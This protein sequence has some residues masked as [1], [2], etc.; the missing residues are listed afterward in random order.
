MHNVDHDEYYNNY[1]ISNY[2]NY[3]NIKTKKILKPHI[4]G[5]YYY[6]NI[7]IYNK[8]LNIKQVKKERINKLVALYF[9]PIPD[10]YKDT[11]I[12]NLV[13]DHIDGNKQNNYYKNL[14]YITIRENVI[15]K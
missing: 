15:K 13:I 8:E 7:N 10:K 9:I 3:R 6:A 5:N 12:N 11:D 1:E 2:G 14:Q 4:S